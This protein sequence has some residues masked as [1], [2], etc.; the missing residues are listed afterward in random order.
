MKDGQQENMKRTILMHVLNY[1]IPQ[2]YQN[3]SDVL[4]CHYCIWWYGFLAV[5]LFALGLFFS[6]GMIIACMTSDNMY[7]LEKLSLLVF[8][9]GVGALCE[10]MGWLFVKYMKNWTVI[11]YENGI[12]YRSVKGEVY[13]Y[14]DAEIKWYVITDGPKHYCITLVTETKKVYINQYSPNY[15]PAK[16]LVRQK[17]KEL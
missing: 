8:F 13:N 2:E 9:I 3:R 6:I 15:H 10:A 12:W 7:V 4:V 14:T 5:I 1:E 17:Y 11:F 16:N